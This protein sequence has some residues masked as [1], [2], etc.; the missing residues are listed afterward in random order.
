MRL[1]II[2]CLVS[3]VA[4]CAAFLWAADDAN[5]KVPFFAALIAGFGAAWLFT[6]LL[7]WIRHGWRAARSMT[8]EP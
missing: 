8:L 3:I 4:G 5:P 1:Q 2:Q 6:F 7:I